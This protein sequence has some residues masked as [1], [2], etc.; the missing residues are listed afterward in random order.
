MEPAQFPEL[1]YAHIPGQTSRH[2]DAVFADLHATV[3]AGMTPDE[4]AKSPAWAAA[5]Y[6][7]RRGY[8]WEAHEMAEALWSVLP[9]AA[10]ERDFLRAFIQMVNAGLKRRMGRPKAAARI[11]ALGATILSGL[12]RREQYLG[13]DLVWLEQ[14]FASHAKAANQELERY[15]K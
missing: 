14:E 10:P 4:L 2:G 3:R 11:C 1:P 6:W 8:Y 5:L 15:A 7:A 9:E 13:I 12:A